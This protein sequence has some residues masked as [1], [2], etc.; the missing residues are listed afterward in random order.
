MKLG[1]YEL[2]CRLGAGG[3][4]Q[5]F[6][7]RHTKTGVEV[8]LKTLSSAT[9]TRLYRFKRE[10]RSLADIAHRNLIR[11]HELVVPDD[12]PAFF[13][14]ERIHGQPLVDWV[15]GSS[16]PGQR[17]DLLRLEQSLRQLVE[18]LAH[19]HAHD[20][21]HRDLKPSNVLVTHD[22]RVVI[23]DFGLI[24]E[25]A[26][27]D[28]GIT[29]DRQVVG[30]PSYMAPEQAMGKR[31]GPATDCY[32]VGVM[33]FQCLTGRLPYGGSALG[34]LLDEG[35]TNIDPGQHAAALP[36]WLCSLCVRLLAI[37]P[38]TRP[39]TRDLQR[40][41]GA[42]GGP[43]SSPRNIFVGRAEQLGAL[44]AALREVNEQRTVVTVHLRGRSGDGKSALA[45]RFRSELGS[46]EATVLHGRCL[47]QE[48]VPFMGVDAVVDALSVW[49]RRQTEDDRKA[50]CPPNFD[51]LIRTFPVL[52]EIWAPP[53]PSEFDSFAVD[54][55]RR[56]AVSSL[57]TLLGSIALHAPLVVH[58][59]D[60]QW[61]NRDSI[62]LLDSLASSSNAP[63]ML[64]LLSYRTG[65][66]DSTAIGDL[67][68]REALA[69]PY[70][71]FIELPPLPTAEAI[72]LAESLLEAVEPGRRP[73]QAHEVARRSKGS[74]LFIQQMALSARSPLG[75]AAPDAS[76]DQLIERRL[77]ALD[78]G[79]RR[80]L[81]IVTT[82]GEPISVEL[83]GKL[84]T[85][86]DPTVDS[87]CEW[88]LLERSEPALEEAQTRI[89]IA[90]DRVREIVLRE[91]DSSDRLRVHQQIG[92]H[93]L[94]RCNGEPEGDEL[95][96]VIRHLAAGI[97]QIDA[98]PAEQRLAFARFHVRAGGRALGSGAWI[99]ALD[100]FRAAH[101]WLEPW[102]A[103]AR[104]GGGQHELC[105]DLVFGR[106]QAEIA[107]GHASGDTVL[108]DLLQWP[109]STKRYGQIAQWYCWNLAMRT[110]FTECIELGMNALSRLG[111]PIPR[112]PS[113]PRALL[114]YL[115][116]WR[117]VHRVGLD[118]IEALP[119]AVDSRLYACLEII[120]AMEACTAFSSDFKLHVMLMG[121]YGRLLAS[122]GLH[123]SAA[124]ALVLLALSAKIRG[125]HEQ[126]EALFELVHRL[127]EQHRIPILSYYE[128]QLFM[129]VSS[130]E[131]SPIGP[132][133]EQCEHF[134]HRSREVAPQLL[135]ELLGFNCICVH[136]FSS[137]PLSRVMAFIDAF[138]ASC[139]DFLLPW[140]REFIAEIRHQI[141]ALRQGGADCIP[142]NDWHELTRS[143]RIALLAW[144]A[145][146]AFALGDHDRAWELTQDLSREHR[147]ERA[148]ALSWS[149]SNYATLSVV[150]M[151]DRWPTARRRERRMMRK[152]M[153]RYKVTALKHNDLCPENFQPALDIID[154]ELAVLDGRDLDAQR[155]YERACGVASTHGLHKLTGLASERL[156]KLA[157]RNGHALLAQQALARARTAYETWGGLAVARR[158]D[159]EQ[160]G[161]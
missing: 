30:T 8:A 135:T 100:Y 21:I 152:M 150:M 125:K 5:V 158:L 17:P 19:L 58:I 154:G 22:G 72:M 76:L 75:S 130:T 36:Q 110:H 65:S 101:E 41:L 10:F 95:F 143:S 93:L 13:T 47:E 6:S 55:V 46:T 86:D 145:H 14:M 85:I 33:L 153:R 73:L 148:L 127:A 3:M 94:A 96:I 54:E 23:L 37:A 90:H 141:R 113:W 43:R 4:G 99:A 160:A 98:L 62:A 97:R 88:G 82:F 56:L 32:A 151:V 48:T 60:V 124:G 157:R 120:A 123:P 64:L 51:A 84:C 137:K 87:L 133:A 59:D 139:G 91:L 18:G 70:A 77:S 111:S 11:L 89:E 106:A 78:H 107:L 79:A 27:P 161:I 92:A 69:G 140:V 40:L 53:E 81:E 118:Q 52:D 9:A 15:R 122:H 149:V 7:A 128:S 102:L 109:L 49:L 131:R 80:L 68:D 129:Q 159:R 114:C 132:A 66:E 155:A 67:L 83:A 2:Q 146:A 29:R 156:A 112:R 50:L 42:H 61:A 136:V 144:R 45:R 39:T 34:R 104:E 57:R 142:S 138:E 126:A 24:S 116:G 20:C 16:P 12:G 147:D 71:R 28:L 115:R 25:L 1:P 74:P 119:P 26:E 134:Y 31:A 117:S 63:A 108:E 105:V 121:V 103:E 44:Y 38:E 35:D